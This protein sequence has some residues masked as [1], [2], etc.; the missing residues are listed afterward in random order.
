M[1]NSLAIL[2][3][4]FGASVLPDSNTHINRLEIKS[5][6]SGNYYTVA[7]NRANGEWGCSCRGWLNARNGHANRKCKHM[8][9]MRPALEAILTASKKPVVID[10][11]KPPR[12]TP[13]RRMVTLTFT[14]DSMT[15]ETITALVSKALTDIHPT[16]RI[17]SIKN[18]SV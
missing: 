2:A 8:T 13:K 15:T 6:T 4:R 7:Q 17:L 1:S 12:D 5:A 3:Q 11:P 16:I 10:T 14:I 18:E 9:A